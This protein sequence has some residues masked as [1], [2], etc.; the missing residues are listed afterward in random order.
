[1]HNFRVFNASV[2]ALVHSKPTVWCTDVDMGGVLPIMFCIYRKLLFFSNATSS[3]F[4]S[5][6]FLTADCKQSIK[7]AQTKCCHA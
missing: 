7:T 6:S 1:M 2:S 5:T 4:S 3:S